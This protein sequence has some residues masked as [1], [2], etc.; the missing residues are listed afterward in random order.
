MVSPASGAPF[1]G[2]ASCKSQR[3]GF[4]RKGGRPP[5]GPAGVREG[6]GTQR[7]LRC[8]GTTCTATGMRPLGSATGCRARPVGAI[9][10]ARA[11]KAE[12]LHARCKVFISS[13]C[14]P[15]PVPFCAIEPARRAALWEIAQ[16]SCQPRRLRA[17]ALRPGINT[18]R[19]SAAPHGVKWLT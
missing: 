7:R 18:E 10:A 16:G 9:A 11:S 19:N 2:C 3:D 12:N 17:A 15:R 14:R 4:A 6:R 1:V 5:K 13:V 8:A